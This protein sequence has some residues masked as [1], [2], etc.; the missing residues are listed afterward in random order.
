MATKRTPIRRG[1]H[2]PLNDAA[3]AAWKKGDGYA[4]MQ[5][6]RIPPWHTGMTPLAV[7]EDHPE[8]SVHTIN[9]DPL[10]WWKEA[11]ALRKELFAVAGRPG[12]HDLERRI[13]NE[14]EMVAHYQKCVDNPQYGGSSYADPAHEMQHRKE[15]LGR[16]QEHLEALRQELAEQ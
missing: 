8:E 6:L 2:R 9:S 3:V 4:L 14:E 1:E 10:G 15:K 5:T 7:H 12:T 13:T 11:V 16:S